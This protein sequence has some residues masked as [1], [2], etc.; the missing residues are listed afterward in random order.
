MADDRSVSLHT[1]LVIEEVPQK[2]VVQTKRNKA[3]IIS[4]LFFG[5]VYDTLRV[6]FNKLILDSL[7]SD[8]RE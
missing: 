7:Y 1:P 8:L 2:V 6:Y 4:Q 3:G 5:W